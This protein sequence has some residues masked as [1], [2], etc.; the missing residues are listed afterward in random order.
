MDDRRHVLHVISLAEFDLGWY[1]IAQELGR[2]GVT[3][4]VELT[5]LLRE[6]AAIGYVEHLE[7]PGFQHG[8]YRLTE[9]GRAFLERTRGLSPRAD[10]L[11]SDMTSHE[12]AESFLAAI[13]HD[14]AFLFEEHGF[15]VVRVE[16]R[17]HHPEYVMVG[18][19]SAEYRIAIDKEW[20]AVTAL[21]GRRSAPFDEA[22]KQGTIDQWF[23]VERLADMLE[24]RPIR[25]PSSHET[26]S[27]EAMI[28][29]LASRLRPV[30]DQLFAPLRDEPLEALS[31][32]YKVY[33]REQIARR[34]GPGA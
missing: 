1:G 17:P 12:R 5:T 11:G 34:H 3:L 33:A 6:L 20:D 22:F 24:G 4:D 32:R 28:A 15:E 30:A 26:V 18:L 2:R 10:Y 27:P 13:R 14:F 16:T 19:E 25:W 21:L 23:N 7:T 9:V 29:Y 31:T 8:I